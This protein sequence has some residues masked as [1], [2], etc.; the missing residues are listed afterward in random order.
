MHENNVQDDMS[1]KATAKWADGEGELSI[2]DQVEEKTDTSAAPVESLA[3]DPDGSSAMVE[4]H[5]AVLSKGKQMHAEPEVT[6]TKLQT[7]VIMLSLGSAFFLS[8]LDY[9]IVTTALPTISGHFHS[10]TGYTWVGSAYMLASAAS[11]LSWGKISDIWGRKPVILCAA[12]I[13]FIGSLLCA[14][15]VNISMLIAARAIQGIGSGGLVLM[16]NIAIGDLFSMRNRGKYYAIIATVW[17][18]AS[19]IG[20]VA[21]GALTEKVSWRWCFYINC[22]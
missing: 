8:A 17:A 12:G 20:P 9:T 2:G 15:S 5:A 4:E 22:K 18:F 16:V 10:G 21:G 13:F 11:T 19:S 1:P 6:R 3:S 14:V 7:A